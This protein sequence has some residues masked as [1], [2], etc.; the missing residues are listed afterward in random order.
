MTQSLFPNPGVNDYRHRTIVDKG[1][2][3]IRAEYP[4]ADRL[5]DR[6]RDLLAVLFVQRDSDVVACGPN[7]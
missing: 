5:G 2:L 4:S 6:R 3:H 7:I 1:N